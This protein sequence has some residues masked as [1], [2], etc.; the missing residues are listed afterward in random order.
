VRINSLGKIKIENKGEDKGSMED[1]LNIPK[2]IEQP[3]LDLVLCPGCLGCHNWSC[4]H[5]GAVMAKWKADQLKGSHLN[6][7]NTRLQIM[8][9]REFKRS[10]KKLLKEIIDGFRSAIKI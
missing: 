3:D 5:N 4:Q 9:H 7:C 6:K 1:F 8:D 10:R 2:K